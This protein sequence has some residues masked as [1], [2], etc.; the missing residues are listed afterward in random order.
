MV[1]WMGVALLVLAAACGGGYLWHE[2]AAARLRRRSRKLAGRSTRRANRTYDELNERL[3]LAV[4][5]ALVAL[6]C[7][8]A[9]LTLLVQ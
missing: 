5:L 9:G 8:A 1:N 7:L 2:R 4:L 3:N 6:L